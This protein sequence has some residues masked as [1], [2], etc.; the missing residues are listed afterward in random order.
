MSNYIDPCGTLLH[1]LLCIKVRNFGLHHLGH[2][3]Q[4]AQVTVLMT[5][6]INHPNSLLMRSVPVCS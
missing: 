4:T 3:L 5:E 6:S 1:C 2:K